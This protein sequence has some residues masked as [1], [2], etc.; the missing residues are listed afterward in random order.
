MSKYDEFNTAYQQTE[1]KAGGGG[2]PW[3]AIEDGEHICEVM[4]ARLEDNERGPFVTGSLY[5]PKWNASE[6]FRFYPDTDPQSV[7][8]QIF[9]R[10]MEKLCP[11]AKSLEDLEKRLPSTNKGKATVRRT[12]KGKYTNHDFLSFEEKIPF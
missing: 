2:R 8:S 10:N 1:V 4:D 7:R 5:Y 6:F 9:K 3:E 12:T 11:G